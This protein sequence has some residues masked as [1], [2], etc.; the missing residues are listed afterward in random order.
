MPGNHGDYWEDDSCI[1]QTTSEC[2]HR[3]FNG[4]T[5]NDIFIFTLGISHLEDE[6]ADLID[7]YRWLA[8]SAVSFKRNILRHFPGQVFYFKTPQPNAMG[9]LWK[10]RDRYEK[11]NH[12]LWDSREVT[13]N[14]ALEN[15][16][17]EDSPCYG[18]TGSA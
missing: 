1:E 9:T 15:M 8:E 4:S 18:K 13:W 7:S 6:N 16:A 3:F 2:F 5:K 17:S 11:L 12:F 14:T 10:T